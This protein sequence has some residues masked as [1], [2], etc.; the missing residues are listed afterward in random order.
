L[1]EEMVISVILCNLIVITTLYYYQSVQKVVEQDL[2]SHVYKEA[3]LLALSIEN[4]FRYA[5]GY[6]TSL[7]LYVPKPYV[8]VLQNSTIMVLRCGRPV[9]QLRLSA[10]VKASIRITYM[11]ELLIIRQEKVVEVH[12]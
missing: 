12:G 10:T 5:P 2:L 1:N 7:T 4:A 6:T 11:R 9:Y 3:E 8:I